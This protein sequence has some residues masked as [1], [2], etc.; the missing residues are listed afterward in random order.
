MNIYRL[1]GLMSG[2]SLDGLDIAYIEFSFD[3]SNIDFDIKTIDFDIKFAETFKYTNDILYEF[4][5]VKDASGIDLLKSHNS[6]GTYIGKQVNAFMNKNNITDVDF[7]ASHGHTIFHQPEL[8]LTFQLGNPAY[9]S[10]ETGIS[11]V[12]DF[13]TLDVAL[14]GQGAPLVPIGDKLLFSEYDF[15]INLGGFANIS[16]DKKE[17]RVA[18]D[19][20]PVNIITNEFAKLFSKD[21]DEDGNIGKQGKIN[22][23]LL[24]SLNN[25]DYYKAKYPK[26]L[27]KEWVDNFFNDCLWQAKI[28]DLDKLRTVY[29]HIS[30]QIANAVNK[31]TGKNILFTGGGTYNGFLLDLIKQKTEKKIIIPDAKIIDFKEALIFGL[32]GVLLIEYKTNTLASVT[33]ASADSVGGCIYGL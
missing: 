14:G 30:M 3:Y 17:S 6:Y 25:L 22:V 8:N 11:C 5:A 4:E 16:F 33:G 18:Y 1:I 24:N 12:G 27:G 21:F 28:P 15:C 13:R 23:G 10:A 32:L 26:S 29:E 19:I 2:T 31:E 9:I 20:C 7:I